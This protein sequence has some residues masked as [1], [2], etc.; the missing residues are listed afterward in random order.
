[1]PVRRFLIALVALAAAALAA[2]GPTLAHPLGNFTVNEYAGLRVRPAEL[3]VDAVLDRAE[4]PTFEVRRRL[5]TDGDGTVSSDEAERARGREC[6]DLS[7]GMELAVGGVRV[8]LAVTAAG[9][10]FPPGSGGLA[11]S[12]LVCQLRAPLA[13]TA[14][15]AEIR[16]SHASG[17]RQP[18]WR[19][20]VVEG[21]EVTVEGARL[22]RTSLSRRLTAYP[23]DRL[24][25]P[26]TVDSVTF[27]ATPGGPALPAFVAPDA[28]P[29]DPAAARD[30]AVAAGPRDRDPSGGDAGDAGARAEPIPEVFRTPLSPAVALLALG[31][32]FVLGGGHALTPGHGKTVIAAW[33]V[34]S[35]SSTSQ[36]AQ[37]GLAVAVAHTL[38]IL[39][40]A[41]LALAGE[42]VLPAGT[43]ALWAPVVAGALVVVVGA[44]ML[45]D[46]LGR[47]QAGRDGG[48]IGRAH[49]HDEGHRHSP[50]AVSRRGLLGLGL[51]G[52]LVPSASALVILLGAIAAGQIA[53]GLVL[54]VAFGLG[55]G[56]V[57]TLLGVLV[58]RG[59]D[60]VAALSTGHG[61]RVLASLPLAAAVVVVGMGAWLTGQA[62]GPIL[63]S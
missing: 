36:A 24:A 55:M 45:V 27:V 25:T 51:A 2:A 61:A 3:L 26:L 52:G 30:A 19:E 18:G 14:T 42:A 15:G 4:I 23:A 56:V 62:L 49:D 32:A 13:I 59:R 34:G 17:R 39:L 54:V 20:I 60:R 38:G 12:R 5:D 6:D 43:V 21:D 8:P 10:S 29:I 53:F 41:L 7:R 47:R 28:S 22:A 9:L 1:M 40:L 50:P 58:V 37:L 44:A 46:A 57:M 11:T 48:E 63:L 31:T 16:F 35:R 33:L